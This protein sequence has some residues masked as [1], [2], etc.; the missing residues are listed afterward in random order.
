MPIRYISRAKRVRAD[1]EEE[2]DYWADQVAAQTQITVTEPDN[3]A[4]VPTGILDQHGTELFRVIEREP[5]GFR[6]KARK[7]T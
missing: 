1:L 5:M 4:P 2:F 6:P 3:E 7:T